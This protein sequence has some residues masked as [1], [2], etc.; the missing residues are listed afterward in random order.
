MGKTFLAQTIGPV[1]Y[2][3]K[4]EIPELLNTTMRTSSLPKKS[5]VKVSVP[6]KSWST[7][8]AGKRS[9][10]WI[11]QIRWM[12]SAEPSNDSKDGSPTCYLPNHVMTNKRSFWSQRASLAELLLTH[13]GC[14]GYNSHKTA[15]RDFKA[16]KIEY[17]GHLTSREEQA[18]DVCGNSGGT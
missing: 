15:V 3:N 16:L 8:L 7:L 6:T 10:N 5:W 14:K 17:V 12:Y 4:W 1:R 2:M 9:I 11:S 13:E 18:K